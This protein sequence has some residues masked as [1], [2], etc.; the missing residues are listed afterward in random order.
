[1]ISPV[2]FYMMILMN[3]GEAVASADR[4]SKLMEIEKFEA[5]ENDKDLEKGDLL[6]ENGDFVWDDVKYFKVFNPKKKDIPTPSRVLKNINISVKSGE[7]IFVVGRV[8]SG[9]SSLL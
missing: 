9:K 5:L 6:V 2:R 1:M 3:Y 4:L 8:G 7:F